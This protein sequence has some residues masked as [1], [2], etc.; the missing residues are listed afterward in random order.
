MTN[1]MTEQTAVD[2]RSFLGGSAVALAGLAGT[3]QAQEAKPGA[4]KAGEA[5]KPTQQLTAFIAGFDL[6]Q[7]PALAVERARTAF[8]DTMGVTLAANATNSSFSDS[9]IGPYTSVSLMPATAH[10]AAI[11]PSSRT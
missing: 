1:D 5:A 7:A 3:A 6:K 9:R 2:R 11:L 10:A 4:A 8:I